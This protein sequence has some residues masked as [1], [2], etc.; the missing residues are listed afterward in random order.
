M[1]L[2]ILDTNNYLYA[3]SFEN[4]VICRGVRENNSEYSAA[5]A[6]IGGI[7]FL[8][9]QVARLSTPDNVVMPVFDRPPDIKREMYKSVFGGIEEYKGNRK[10]TKTA[11]RVGQQKAYAEQILRDLGYPVQ[12]ADGYEA[13][14]LI[15]TIVNMVKDE[16]EHIYIH[17]K[18]SDLDFLVDENVSIYPVGDDGKTITRWNYENVVDKSHCLFCTHHLRKLCSGDTGDNIPGIGNEWAEKMDEVIPDG[19]YAKLG[20]LDL[21]RKYLKETILRNPTMPAGYRV[22]QTFNI[23]AP[24]NVPY[25]EINEDE[26]DIDFDKLQYYLLGWNEKM[27]RWGLEDMLKDYIDSTFE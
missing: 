18:D 21:C 16:Y 2:H 15:Y 14:D 25:E 8:I 7:R 10:F 24:L 26:Q 22:L 17:T 4:S 23:L 12:V 6:P 9:K 1:N 5:S 19:D 20:D 3:G 27:D 11:Q 13:D